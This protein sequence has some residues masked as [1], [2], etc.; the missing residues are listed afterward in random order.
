MG[1]EKEFTEEQ[2]EEFINAELYYGKCGCGWFVTDYPFVSCSACGFIGCGSAKELEKATKGGYRI[3]LRIEPPKGV[4]TSEIKD[5]T[6][7]N[8]YDEFDDDYMDY[9]GY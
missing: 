7:H 9:L 5:C 1:Q 3:D 8:A 4:P 6:L 2:K